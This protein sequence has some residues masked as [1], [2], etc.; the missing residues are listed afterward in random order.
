MY[1]NIYIYMSIL[2]QCI[3]DSFFF[4]DQK[5]RRPGVKVKNKKKKSEK[6]IARSRLRNVILCT[7][8]HTYINTY[9]RKGNGRREREREREKRE[10]KD[11]L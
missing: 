10:K 6:G 8:L 3:S 4:L 5:H 9:K 2:I 7:Y 1:V 11:V